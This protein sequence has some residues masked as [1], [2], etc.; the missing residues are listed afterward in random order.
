VEYAILKKSGSRLYPDLFSGFANGLHIT[1]S[2]RC[3]FS[4]R[5]NTGGANTGGANTGGACGG[6]HCRSNDPAN[7]IID[8]NSYPFTRRTAFC[9]TFRQ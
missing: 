6:A 7:H 1:D 9:G 4:T 3:A 5:A 2:N 8:H